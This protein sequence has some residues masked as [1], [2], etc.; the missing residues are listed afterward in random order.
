MPVAL[1]VVARPSACAGLSVAHW[2]GEAHVHLDRARSGRGGA[3]RWP[4]SWPP[5]SLRGCGSRPAGSRPRRGGGPLTRLAVDEGARAA[6][7]VADVDLAVLARSITAWMRETFGSSS[8]RWLLGS[9]PI[10]MK[11]WS[12]STVRTFWPPRKM[13]KTSVP[14]LDMVSLIVLARWSWTALSAARLPQT[15]C[16]VWRS[17]Q[18]TAAPRGFPY[19]V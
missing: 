11:S 2:G 5:T 9:L 17:R 1:I 13:S 16:E 7:E 14:V 15:R 6:A 12:S 18:T 19:T 10:L 4:R 3:P 8:C